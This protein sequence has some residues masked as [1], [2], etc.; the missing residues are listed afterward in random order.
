MRVLVTNC[1]RVN[2]VQ[3]RRG[4]E[5]SFVLIIVLGFAEAKCLVKGLRREGFLFKSAIQCLG[6]FAQIG[7]PQAFQYPCCFVRAGFV[8]VITRENR[9]I[10]AL[11]EM[12]I[13]AVQFSSEAGPQRFDRGVEVLFLREYFDDLPAIFWHIAKSARLNQGSNELFMFLFS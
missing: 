8:S 2:S 12:A 4:L 9:E 5:C 3:C 13:A 7:A 6:S 11:F 10:I 1:L